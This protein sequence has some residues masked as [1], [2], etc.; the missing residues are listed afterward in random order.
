MYCYLCGQAI[1]TEP[2]VELVN[3]VRAHDRCRDKAI[4]RAISLGGIVTIAL[5]G[6][7]G[8]LRHRGW[9]AEDVDELIEEAKARAGLVW[10]PATHETPGA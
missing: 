10:P 5:D 3:G 8:A 1:G 6:V 7:R 9:S 2:A 4:L